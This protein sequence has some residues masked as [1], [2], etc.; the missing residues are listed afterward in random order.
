MWGQVDWGQDGEEENEE[1]E[2]EKEEEEE[3]EEKLMVNADFL[4]L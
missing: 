4:L 2:R 1:E 3:E